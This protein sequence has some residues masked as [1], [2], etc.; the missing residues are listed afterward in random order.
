MSTLKDNLN[1]VKQTIQQTAIDCGRDPNSIQL[2]AVSKTQAADA[3]R[4]AYQLG[5]TAFGENY[6]QE[7][8]EKQQALS[9]LPIEWHFIGPIQSNKTRVIAE[10]FHWAHSVDRL[11][12]AQR[13]ND[14]RPATLPPLNICLQVNLDGE[15]SKS[16]LELEALP[17]LVEKIQT[18]PRIKLRGLMSIPAPRKHYEEQYQV[19]MRLN[20]A[21][22]TLKTKQADL[23]SLSMGMSADLPAAIAAGATIVRIGTA[24]FGKRKV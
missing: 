22:N 17:E 20:Q 6:L 1:Q 12:V 16:G 18:M 7:A 11:K 9:D 2:L 8:R 13:L 19:F 10:H 3:L 5:Q 24:I 15:A 4:A 21:L 23:D 14:A